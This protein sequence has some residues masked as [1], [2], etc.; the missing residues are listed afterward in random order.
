MNTF[1]TFLSNHPVEPEANKDTIIRGM[2]FY[3]EAVEFERDAIEAEKIAVET[4]KAAADLQIAAVKGTL[5]TVKEMLGDREM[6]DDALLKEI[7]RLK[8]LDK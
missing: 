2:T 1:D 6:P 4:E 3:V 8:A 5:E 7:E